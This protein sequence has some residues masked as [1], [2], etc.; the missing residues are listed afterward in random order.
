MK[1]TSSVNEDSYPTGVQSPI[2]GPELPPIAPMSKRLFWIRH[3]EVINP[4]G[5]KAVFY[6][7]M[8]VALS[9]FGE[10]EAKV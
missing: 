9:P 3:G 8:D 2:K 1:M 7:S 4:G 10:L 5:D 6:G